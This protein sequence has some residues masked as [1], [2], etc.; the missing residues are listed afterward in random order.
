MMQV[1]GSAVA[2][3]RPAFISMPKML[4]RQK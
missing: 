1:T 2:S 3:R 4:W